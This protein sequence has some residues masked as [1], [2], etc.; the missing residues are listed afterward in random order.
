MDLI[1][2]F[3]ILFLAAVMGLF[4]RLSHIRDTV[5]MLICSLTIPLA[6]SIA[7]IIPLLFSLSIFWASLPA[8]IFFSVGSG[9]A[10]Y[11]IGNLILKLKYGD[12]DQQVPS[13]LMT[14]KA[15]IGV[16]IILTLTT[17]YIAIMGEYLPEF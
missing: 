17:T 5:S 11:I 2:N 16:L 13:K 14:R 7:N 10:G 1:F 6:W 12:A 3:G 8:A 4:L 9:L 15:L